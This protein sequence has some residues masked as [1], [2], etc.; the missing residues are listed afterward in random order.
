MQIP[1]LKVLSN[2]K[3]LTMAMA[4]L[5]VLAIAGVAIALLLLR[6]P[7]TGGG[8]IKAAPE[9]RYLAASVEAQDNVTCSVT[10]AADGKS[11]DLQLADITAGAPSR[12][13]VTFT[14]QKAN[15]TENLVIQNVKFSS[16]TTE[17]F[18]NACG[19]SLNAGPTT[20]SAEFAT[21]AN[22]QPQTFTADESNAGISVVSAADYQGANCPGAV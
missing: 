8:N 16:A 4:A 20:I 12:C 9:L 1:N 10:V 11:A 2:K 21:S 6:A 18:P 7:L 22:A 3:K 14:V 13:R 17:S 19:V 5:T 15:T